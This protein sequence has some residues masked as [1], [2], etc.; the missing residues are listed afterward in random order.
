MIKNSKKTY[1]L[2][3]VLLSATI[4]IFRDVEDTP[5]HMRLLATL[6][7]TKVSTTSTRTTTVQEFCTTSKANLIS[8]AERTTNTQYFSIMKTYFKADMYSIFDLEHR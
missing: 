8:D 5:F 7:A 3:L 4:F 1:L 2:V 6:D